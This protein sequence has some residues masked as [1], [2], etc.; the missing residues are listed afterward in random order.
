MNAFFHS[1]S[2]I[3]PNYNNAIWLEKCIQSCLDQGEFLKEI[4]I[5]DDHST[6]NSVEIIENLKD[7]HPNMMK[8]FINP[9][10]GANSARNFGFSKS[11]GDFIQWLDSDDLILPGKFKNQLKGFEEHVADVVYSDWRLDFYE[12]NEIVKKEVKKSK[13]YTDYAFQLLLDNWTCSH[14]Y[15]IKR[16]VAEEMYKILAWNP[17]TR[18]GQDREYFTYV[19]LSGWKF[20]YVQGEY[21]VYNR[22]SENT[23]SGIDFSTRLE[24]NQILEDRFRN[25]IENSKVISFQKKK[26][27][28]R[29]L[30]SHLI[31]AIYYNRSIRLKKLLFPWELNW[32]IIHWKMRF[33]IPFLLVRSNI[34]FYFSNKLER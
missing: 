33:T 2:V 30:N 12:G 14:N 6:D 1:V 25:V 23:I 27:Y 7:R 20:H 19:A 26:R 13:A 15:L 17:R 16:N 8:I 9:D 34:Q 4:I 32:S 5:V 18:V 29:V 22:W 11:T 28:L 24:L 3:I 31:K 21:S 10:K